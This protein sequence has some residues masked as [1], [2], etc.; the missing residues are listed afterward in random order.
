IVASLIRLAWVKRGLPHPLW[1]NAVV[2]RPIQRLL[3]PRSPPVC[4]AGGQPAAT[5]T[6]AAS[7]CPPIIPYSE[8]TNR[9]GPANRPVTEGLACANSKCIYY[10][11]TDAQIHEV[12]GDGAEGK[13]ERRETLRWQACTTTFSTDRQLYQ[14][15]MLAATLAIKRIEN[16]PVDV[17]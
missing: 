9:R 15:G 3:R 10:S 12:V 5:P 7:T 8:R 1:H 14:A 16:S 11:V 6:H 2:T 17:V 4:P 13:T